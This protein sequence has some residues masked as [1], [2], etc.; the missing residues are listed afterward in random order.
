MV[1]S[2][3][4][5]VSEAFKRY[6]EENGIDIRRIARECV[7][8]GE[9]YNQCEYAFSRELRTVIEDFQAVIG[10]Y[11]ADDVVMAVSPDYE[12][13]DLVDTDSLFNDKGVAYNRKPRAK[14]KQSSQCV[15]KS[16]AKKPSKANGSRN[17]K[18]GCYPGYSEE[19]PG[20]PL[21][22]SYGARLVRCN[23]CM[24]LFNEYETSDGPYGDVCPYC[25][26][27][28]GLMDVTCAL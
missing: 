8:P 5:Y 19:Y 18:S 10:D 3:D 12:F 25:G 17:A 11:M 7:V 6:V 2:F 16:T 28:G 15:K 13:E 14:P 26:F 22:D 4:D 20:G 23:N 27:D 1:V 24:K 9:T 21:V